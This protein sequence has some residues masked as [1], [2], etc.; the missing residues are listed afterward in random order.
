MLW[1]GAGNKVRG[2]YSHGSDRDTTSEPC[3]RRLVNAANALT[4]GCMIVTCAFSGVFVKYLG[5]RWTLII[6]AAGYCPYTAGLYCN[7]RFGSAWFVLLGATCCGLGAGLF[8]MAEAAIA[9][10]YPE[11]CNQGRF[12]ST[13]LTFRV[14]GQVLGGAIN[15]GLNADRDEAGAVSYKVYQVFIALQACAP[16]VGLF[17]TAPKKVTR[18]DGVR[19]SCSIPRDQSE[20]LRRRL[21]SWD[22]EE[23][24]H[25]DRSLS[26]RSTRRVHGDGA[27]FQEQAFSLGHSTDC[28]IGILGRCVLYVPRSVVHGSSKSTG[29]ISIRIG[30]DTWRSLSGD[31]SRFEKTIC[32]SSWARVLAHSGRAARCLVDMGNRS[33]DRIST[34]TPHA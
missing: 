22:S 1:V 33:R 28:F 31:L 10:S 7:N 8:W 6:G 15:L 20:S 9:L 19:V 23:I 12:L 13:W 24:T 21:R 30:R 27:A 3:V 4:C 14:A 29:L 17:V 32:E 18:T 26:L 16:F 5:I 25:T 2:E 34:D 11:S